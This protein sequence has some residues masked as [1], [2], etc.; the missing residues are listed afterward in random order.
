MKHP[1]LL[2]KKM[3]RQDQADQEV[4]DVHEVGHFHQGDTP[5]HQDGLTPE[6]DPAPDRRRVNFVK[7]ARIF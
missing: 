6:A 7:Q 4:Q 3:S 2:W 5:D 1:M